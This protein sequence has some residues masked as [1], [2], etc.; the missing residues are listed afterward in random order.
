MEFVFESVYDQQAVAAMARALR[1][2]V[3]KKHSR[4]SH[5][6]GWIVVAAALALSFTTGEDGFAVTGKTVLTWLVVLLMVVTL[7]FED[8]INGYF[9]RKRALPGTEHTTTTFDA[10]GY[11]S[12]NTAGDTRWSYENVQMFAEDVNYF[13]FVLNVNHAQVYD[14]RRMSGGTEAEFRAFL[15][16]VAGKTVE[17]I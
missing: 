11:S 15:Q 9:A 12:T 7:L 1:K 10:E 3:R 4:R 14:K 8:A 2:T 13:V 17:K 5:I 6:I 16:E